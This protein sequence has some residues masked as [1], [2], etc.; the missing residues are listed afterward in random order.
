MATK[1][2]KAAPNKAFTLHQLI[3]NP[4][5]E[6]YG[7]REFDTYTTLEEAKSVARKMFGDTPFVI[8]ESSVI[9]SNVENFKKG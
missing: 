7:N 1:F 6:S 8:T 5:E 2:I 3:W 9:L 4:R